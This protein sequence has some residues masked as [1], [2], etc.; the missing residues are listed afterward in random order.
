MRQHYL[1]VVRSFE[2]FTDMLRAGAT[3][4]QVKEAVI[5]LLDPYVTDKD[6]LRRLSVSV[7]AN[8]ATCVAQ[9]SSRPEWKEILDLAFSIRTRAIEASKAIAFDTLCAFEE[10]IREAQRKYSLQIVFEQPKEGLKLDEYAFEMF[11]LIGSLTESTIQPF[12][13]ELYCLACIADGRPVSLMAVLRTDFGKVV[14]DF[15][16]LLSNPNFLAP[17]P[18][19]LRISQWRNIAQHHSYKVVGEKVAVHYGKGPTPRSVEVTRDELFLL[20]KELIRRLGAMK[21]TRELT[22]LNHIGELRPLLPTTGAH[23]Y[24]T[25]TELVAAFATQC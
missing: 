7:L 8:E 15:E 22:I 11:R 25:A 5:A 3:S 2:P 13:K 17:H 20:A 10:H 16:R 19:M 9:L 14:E 12:L 6:L 24:G 18:W 21:S 1:E 23:V 4:S